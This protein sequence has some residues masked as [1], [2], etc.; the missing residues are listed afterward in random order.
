MTGTLCESRATIRARSDAVLELST[1]TTF[2]WQWSLRSLSS[3]WE[4]TE[5]KHRAR[6]RG[7]SRVQM[8]TTTSCA[9]AAERRHVSDRHRTRDCIEIYSHWRFSQPFRDRI[10]VPR[11]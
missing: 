10:E 8:Q 9:G 7:R 2:N 5:V 1:T 4:R 3:A 11:E 6:P